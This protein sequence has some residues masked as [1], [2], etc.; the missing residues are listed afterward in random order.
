MTRENP[1]NSVDRTQP[2]P[3]AIIG[4]AC[5]FPKAEDL[6]RYWSNIRD[7]VD[8]ITDVPETHWNPADY[9]DA[10]PSAPDRT[11]ARRGGFLTPVDFPP[12]DFG[13]APNNLEATD[14]TQLL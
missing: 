4:M 14:T 10:D 11:Y 8:A 5:M 12:L 13:I 7:R 3:V 9:F 6:S 1:L 2:V